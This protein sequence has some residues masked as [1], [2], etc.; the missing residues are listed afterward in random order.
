VPL[1]TF[2]IT[3]VLGAGASASPPGNPVEVAQGSDQA[4]AFTLDADHKLSGILL[5]GIEQSPGATFTIYNVQADHTLEVQTVAGKPS[6]TATAGTGGTILPS[7]SFLVTQ[8]TSQV[9]SITGG[10]GYTVESVT[11]DGVPVGFAA[12]LTLANIVSDHTIAV[13]FTRDMVNA[14]ADAIV[15]VLAGMSVAGGWSVDFAASVATNPRAVERNQGAVDWQTVPRPYAAVS[16]SGTGDNTL[17]N[18]GQYYRATGDFAVRF[19]LSPP[20]SAAIDKAAGERYAA[21]VMQEIIRAVVAD[22]TLFGVLQTGLLWAKESSAG[23]NV[24]TGTLL[25]G[26][27]ITFGATWEWTP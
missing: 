4:F 3:L 1:Q 9:F 13:R 25:C 17:L 12:L 7:G 6:L 22:P 14:I 10:N 24:D 8:G 15:Q 18:A 21:K 16:Y 11:L 19:L 20:A 27:E 26:G 23:Q 5:D 2:N